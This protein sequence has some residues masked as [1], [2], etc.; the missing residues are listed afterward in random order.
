MNGEAKDQQTELTMSGIY[1]TTWHILYISCVPT[2]S[3]RRWKTW[4]VTIITHQK[5]TGCL[6]WQDHRNVVCKKKLKKKKK[7]IPQDSSAMF[8]GNFWRTQIYNP[9]GSQHLVD[10]SG[11]WNMKDVYNNPKVT[12]EFYRKRSTNKPIAEIK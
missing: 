9:K 1:F 6:W 10:E 12:I 5:V 3:R 7:Y 2:R 8:P 4:S 11:L